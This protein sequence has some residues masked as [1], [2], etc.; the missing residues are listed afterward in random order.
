[1]AECP[2]CGRDDFSS[3]LGMKSHHKQVHDESIADGLTTISLTCEWCSEEYEQPPAYADQNEH[4]FCSHDCYSEWLTENNTGE[5]HPLWNGGDVEVSCETC[6]ETLARPKHKIE[7]AENHFCSAQCQG[8]YITKHRSGEDSPHFQQ[9]TVGCDNCDDDV[10][11]PPHRI[12]NVENTFCSRKCRIEFQCGED[13]PRWRGGCEQYYGPTWPSQRR[14]T[15]ERDEY[16]CQDCGMTRDE[17]YEQWGHDLEVHHKT[18]IKT[19]DDTAEANK[20]SN[21]I[22]LCKRCHTER[23]NA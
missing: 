10:T 19:F 17:H 6:G 16:E 9:I 23:E 18:P 12:L 21:L 14:K 4:N 2:T 8:K 11:R 3:E 15:L 5:D 1:M 22:T 13:H 20:L 7:N